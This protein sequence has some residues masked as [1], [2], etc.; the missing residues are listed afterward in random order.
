MRPADIQVIGTELTIKWNDGSGQFIPLEKLRW[1]CP[2]AG[3]K[4][5]VDIMSNVYKNPG[6]VSDPEGSL[7]SV[8]DM[9]YCNGMTR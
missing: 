9:N 2:C 6:K 3:C 8:P 4:G 7:K 1:C 5:G